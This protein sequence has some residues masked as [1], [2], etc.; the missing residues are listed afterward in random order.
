MINPERIKTLPLTKVDANWPDYQR[1]RNQLTSLRAANPDMLLVRILLSSGKNFRIAVDSVP[2]TAAGHSEPGAI[3]EYPPEELFSVMASGKPL[4]TRSPVKGE[5][6]FNVSV[7]TPLANPADGKTIAVL[8]T[9]FSPA[10]WKARDTRYRLVA[11]VTTLFFAVAFI[12][13]FILFQRT[14]ESAQLLTE[15]QK[16]LEESRLQRQ[17][18]LEAL[19][20]SLEVA[21]ELRTAKLIEANQELQH[22]AYI[23][24]HDLQEPLRTITSFIQLLAKRYQGKLDKD[25]DEFIGFITDGAHRMQRL[26]NDLL[27]Y[28]R[29][30]SKGR[31]FVQFDCGVALEHCLANLRHSIDESGASITH[32]NPPL[33]CGD[34]MQMVQLLQNLVG[35]AIKFRSSVP[36]LIH[37]GFLESRDEWEISVRDN[38]IGM[39]RKSFDRI[40][41]IFHRLHSR[42]KY[43]GTG[44]GLAVCKKIVERHGGCIRVDS[45]PGEGTTFSFTIKKAL[46]TGTQPT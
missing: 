32:D 38:G 3:Y 1:V 11:I 34:E 42:D 20:C 13:F 8:E 21:V 36:P 5:D 4:A 24:S 28:S 23:A 31:P 35:N 9:V 39:E 17:H 10:N 25:A 2:E 43:A 30:E 7:L 37:I 15:S 45:A 22:F 12:L 26:I 33:I 29:V 6:S 16:K 41:E 14:L 44:I 40:F 46:Q 19:N 18:E 27:A